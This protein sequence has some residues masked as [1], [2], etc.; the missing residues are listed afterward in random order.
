MRAGP[1]LRMDPC[2]CSAL[3][4][5]PTADASR[6]G[7]LDA[8]CTTASLARKASSICRASSTFNEFFAG[9]IRRAQRAACLSDDAPRSMRAEQRLCG[10]H[11]D[12][13]ELH[14]D[15]KPLQSRSGAGQISVDKNLNHPD[16]VHRGSRD[17]PW[18]SPHGQVSADATDPVF[19]VIKSKD[20]EDHTG[21]DSSCRMP[22]TG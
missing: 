14:V 17:R 5:G 1:G 4:A 11:R 21:L 12:R 15:Q 9:R 19:L 20:H 6:S 8:A 16:I 3:G 7:S 10:F 13:A 22:R 2:A 18:P